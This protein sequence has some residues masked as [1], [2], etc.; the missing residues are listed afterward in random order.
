MIR[1]SAL[2]HSGR[3]GGFSVPSPEAQTRVVSEALAAAGV[4]ARTI[5]YV[6]AHGSGTTLGDQIELEA[7]TA[8]YRG[9]TQDRGYCAIGSVKTGIGHLEAA[10]GIASLTKVIHA[11]RRRT[12]PATRVAGELNP[13][14]RF[15]DT[16]STCPTRPL[17]GRRRPQIRTPA[18]RYPAE[19]G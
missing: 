12:I 6:E 15:E 8:A 19:R 14:L 13:A 10:A 5:G 1:G 11:L 9:S 4:P 18:P 2:R 7:L 17:P 16:P 3:T